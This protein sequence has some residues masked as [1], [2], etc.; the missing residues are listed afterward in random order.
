[1][2]QHDL[3]HEA[4]TRGERVFDDA[5][6]LAI[7]IVL[8]TMAIPYGSPTA[9]GFIAGLL[10]LQV[11]R[12]FH[13]ALDVPSLRQLQIGEGVLLS[14]AGGVYLIAGLHS[15]WRNDVLAEDMIF[16][17]GIAAVGLV[18][19]VCLLRRD[20]VQGTSDRPE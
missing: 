6:R 7:V 5:V 14:V 10:L 18:A 4:S 8:L 20:A 3:Q 19:G 9:V 13:A 16:P 11:L 12:L 2:S 17:L 15:L 1:M